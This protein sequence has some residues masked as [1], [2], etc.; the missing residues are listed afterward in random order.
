MYPERVTIT[1]PIF[2]NL[3]PTP[4]P[5]IP[6]NWAFPLP[7]NLKESASNQSGNWLLSKHV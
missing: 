5:Q 4:R 2:E 1:K 7:R 3:S 6:E